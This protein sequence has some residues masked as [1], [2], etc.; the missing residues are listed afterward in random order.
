MIIRNGVRTFSGN[1]MLVWKHLV[2]IL[3]V[4]GISVALFLWSFE[5]VVLRLK[6]SGWINE[7]YGFLEV[8]YT[9]PIGVADAFEVLATNLYLALFKDIGAIWGSY[10]LSLFALLVLPY[11][12]YN[13]G[14]YTLGVL[15]HSRMSSLLNRS[16]AN[17][18]IST[19]AR[20]T[21]YSLWKLLINI[22][23]FAIIVGLAAGYGM[24][25]NAINGA[26]L[27]LPIFIALE[28]LVF[29]FRY[30]FFIGFL[31]VAVDSEGLVIKAFTEGL[32]LYTD[33]YMK[34]VLLVWALYIVE[35]AGVVAIALFSLGAG[36]LVAVPSIMVIN[37]ACSFVNY[38]QTKKENFYVGDNQIV[39]PL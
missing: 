28:L 37:V 1:F 9:D 16:Y 18:F 29:A 35:L 26:W 23:F 4:A 20:S 3:I 2:Y 12:L 11:F 17:T 15:T 38:F 25:A 27:L 32:D 34:K 30:V 8:F 5:P 31:P 22:P 21:R 19:L 33:G 7:F 36:L 39:K 13:I 10:A 6:D 14:E 24:L